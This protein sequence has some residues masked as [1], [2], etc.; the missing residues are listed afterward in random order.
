[1]YVSPWCR[2][3]ELP[4]FLQVMLGV[5]LPVAL[6][7]RVR[8][9]PSRTTWST[10]ADSIKDGS[11]CI[12]GYRL[13]KRDNKL[14]ILTIKQ[15]PKL[16]WGRTSPMCS[17]SL[18]IRLKYSIF[19]PNYLFHFK[20]EKVIS[21]WF[22]ESRPPYREFLICTVVQNN[23]HALIKVCACMGILAGNITKIIDVHHTY[24]G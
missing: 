12:K 17:T 4:S 1:M 7:S 10:G 14:P 19:S 22:A 13:N 6:Q 24:S 16:T 2:T 20:Y 5:G 9:L 11:E 21:L 23:T 15:Q 8:L 3:A 18:G